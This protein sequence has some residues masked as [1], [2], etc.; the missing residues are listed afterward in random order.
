MLDTADIVRD[1]DFSQPSGQRQYSKSRM[2]F[3][4]S[5]LP[6]EITCPICGAKVC[7]RQNKNSQFQPKPYCNSCGWNVGRAHRQLSAQLL[8]TVAIGALFAVYAWVIIGTKWGMLVACGLAVMV[9]GFPLVTRLRHL[10][11]SRPTPSLQPT[12]GIVDFRTVTLD[13][14]TPRLNIIVEG[15]IVVI[16]ALAM[17]FLA[18]ELNSARYTLPKMTHQLLFVVLTTIFAAYLFV[19]HAVLF[20]RLMR[21]IWLERHLSKGAVTVRGRV[22][23]SNSGRIKYEFLDHASRLSRGAGRDYT[24][25]LYEDMPLSILYDP[26]Q[27]SLNMPIAGLQFHRPREVNEYQTAVLR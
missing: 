11:P 7:V 13:T 25:G 14:M 6:R 16:A 26:D 19:I 15:L 9:M 1:S 5:K 22:I 21:S 3:P 27:P 8:Q 20:F 23:D 2:L 12:A 24:M 4:W 10:P 18:R 17:L